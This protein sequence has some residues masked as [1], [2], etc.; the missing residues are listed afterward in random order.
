[1]V[2]LIGPSWDEAD[3][4]KLEALMPK[5]TAI[6]V[7]PGAGVSGAL[8]NI[9]DALLDCN[10]PTVIDADGLNTLAKRDVIKLRPD[11]I[12][13]PHPG[14]MARLIKS[15]IQQ[16][17]SDP[18]KAAQQAAQAFGCVVLLKGVTSVIA[19]PDGELTFNIT[20]NASLAKGGSGD[21]LTGIIL[22][23]VA[24]GMAAYDA[25]C[26]AS[27]I[28]GTAAERVTKNLEERC[29]MARDVIAE[30]ENILA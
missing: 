21:V 22:S 4:D 7:G 19:S 10:L 30:L 6:A 26:L 15:D 9:I 8:G 18:V 11:I 5:T 27:F 20:G 3:M 16:V 25:A 14:E 1:M 28:L 2:H 24:Q 23:L 29:V 12:L 13:T 17:L